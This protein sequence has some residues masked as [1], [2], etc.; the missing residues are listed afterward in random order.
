[1]QTPEMISTEAAIHRAGSSRSQDGKQD[2]DERQCQSRFGKI[3][4]LAPRR[5][6]IHNAK[7]I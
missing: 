6:N 2:G 4:P 1:M 3:I 5:S 7:K